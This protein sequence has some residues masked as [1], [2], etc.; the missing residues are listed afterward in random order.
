MGRSHGR[1]STLSVM[2]MVSVGYLDSLIQR[3]HQFGSERLGMEGQFCL[4]MIYIKVR[5]YY[6]FIF[7]L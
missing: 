7:G 4:R 1:E 2:F 3:I 5:K 6:F